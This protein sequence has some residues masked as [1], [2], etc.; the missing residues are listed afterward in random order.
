VT[1]LDSNHDRICEWE[2]L[3]PEEMM[4]A[5]ITYLQTGKYLTHI[6]E[7]WH[8]LEA[9]NPLE[10][11]VWLIAETKRETAGKLTTTKDNPS[12]GLHHQDSPQE[13]AGAFPLPKLTKMEKRRLKRHRWAEHWI[14]KL[15]CIRGY[16]HQ[17]DK[18]GWTRPRTCSEIAKWAGLPPYKVSRIAQKALQLGLIAKQGRSYV[19][20][21]GRP[22]R[23]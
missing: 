23:V 15:L 11:K 19:P 13:R 9:Q 6:H 5:A 8:K 3:Q 1:Y 10:L 14:P 2:D 22:P 12:E 4:T 7:Q 16:V 18:Y 20:K 21:V 17:R